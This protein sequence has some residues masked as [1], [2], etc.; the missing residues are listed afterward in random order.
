MGREVGDERGRV[1]K[2]EKENKGQGKG[3]RR[4]KGEGREKRVI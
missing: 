4:R 3:Q 1:R 2:G